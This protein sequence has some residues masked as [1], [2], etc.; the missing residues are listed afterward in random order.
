MSNKY[1]KN[2]I[3]INGVEVDR[4]DV[5]FRPKVENGQI[6]TRDGVTYD[7]DPVTGNLRKVKKS[8]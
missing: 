7:R 5:V 4:A 8:K 3:K 2:V 1:N 6:K